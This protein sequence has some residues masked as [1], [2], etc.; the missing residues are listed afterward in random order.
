MKGAVAT[1]TA[2]LIAA[3]GVWSGSSAYATSLDFYGPNGAGEDA[4]YIVLYSGVDLVD[5]AHFFYS[6]GIVALNRDISRSGFLLQGFV[7]SG[8]YEYFTSDVP[9]GKVDADLTMLRAMLGYQVY[10]SNMR[11]A[12]YGGVD[13]QDNDLNPR[14]PENPVAGEETGFIASG[15]LETVETRPLYLGLIGQYS[16]ANKTYWSRIRGGYRFR[17]IVAGPEGVFFGN[18]ESPYDAQRAGG[19]VSLPININSDVSFELTAAGGY[20]WVSEDGGGFGGIGGSSNS[21]Y[22]NI[23]FATAF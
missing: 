4:T 21:A 23:G 20:Q 17:H 7:G 8:D 11:F 5:D 3:L 9:G 2:S 14:D 15:E 1:V 22:F 12:L 16:T 6:G 10:S 13:W 18:G 19:F